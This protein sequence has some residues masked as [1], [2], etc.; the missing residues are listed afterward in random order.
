M[1]WSIVQ[2]PYNEGGESSA[3]TDC[4]PAAALLSSRVEDH[5][6]NTVFHKVR[7]VRKIALLYRQRIKA[8]AYAGRA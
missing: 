7:A 3:K 8:G 5:S 2:E 4:K 1:V 6:L